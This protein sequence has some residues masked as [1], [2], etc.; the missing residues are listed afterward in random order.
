VYI[1]T[2]C[3]ELETNLR[4]FGKK[5]VCVDRRGKTGW[6]LLAGENCIEGDIVE[7]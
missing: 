4:V 2:G 1:I 7:K 5:E 6:K 3:G